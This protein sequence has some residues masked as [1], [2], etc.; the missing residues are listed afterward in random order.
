[1][2]WFQAKYRSHGT[3]H[4]HSCLRLKNDPGVDKLTQDVL[5]ARI[6]EHRL[7]L[8]NYIPEEEL[9]IEQMD[10]EF[11]KL[12]DLQEFNLIS[13]YLISITND[14]IDKEK[15]TIQKGKDLHKAIVAF[16]DWM[17][18]SLHPN[19]PGDAIVDLKRT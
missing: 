5:K 18:T 1:M 3:A 17:F 16:H 19:P 6:A 13:D 14:E 15:K 11:L 8:L 7:K 2:V 10:N 4:V 12:Y 9:C